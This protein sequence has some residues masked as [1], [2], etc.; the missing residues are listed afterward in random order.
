MIVFFMLCVHMR[1]RDGLRSEAMHDDRGRIGVEQ[2]LL[3]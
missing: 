2:M 1:V 3:S